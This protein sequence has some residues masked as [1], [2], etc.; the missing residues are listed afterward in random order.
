MVVEDTMILAR[1]IN[2]KE[3]KSLPS[4]ND[5]DGTDPW[6]FQDDGAPCHRS[7]IVKNWVES[8][9]IDTLG[10]PGNSLDFNPIENF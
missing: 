4:A 10:W 3:I 8:K 1:Y 5:F 9:S 2:T 6:I 7:G